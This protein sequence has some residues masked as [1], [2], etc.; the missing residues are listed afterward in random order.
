MITHAIIT[1]MGGGVVQTAPLS[2]TDMSA[3]V[4][5]AL[6][7]SQ[8]TCD[9]QTGD[10][11]QTQD[12]EESDM[13][14]I[15]EHAT[16]EIKRI[17]FDEPEE[18]FRH[19][20]IYYASFIPKGSDKPI[21]ECYSIK[22]QRIISTDELPDVLMFTAH[23]YHEKTR[24][25]YLGYFFCDVT[26]GNVIG[27]SHGRSIHQIRVEEGNV[28][29]ATIEHATNEVKRRCAEAP[30]EYYRY[31]YIYYRGFISKGSVKPGM[32]YYSIKEQ[33][34]ISVDELPDVLIFTAYIE[35]EKTR[36]CHPGGAGYF[37]CDATTG[38]LI[39]YAHQ[40]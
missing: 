6:P 3:P 31:Q 15:I 30:E 25:D 1:I 27:Y 24:C 35:D 11:R 20:Y 23:F 21:E 33:R 16:N 32:F 5:K 38:E 9:S 13:E 37:Y 18:G 4:T 10:T 34:L 36:Y 26:T 19:Q 28:S 39:G 14:A 2:D 12:E 7:V 17:S 8:G 40:M 22:E 29:E